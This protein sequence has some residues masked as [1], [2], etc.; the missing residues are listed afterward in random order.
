ML[1]KLAEKVKTLPRSC[2]NYCDTIATLVNSDI[3]L[4]AEQDL[5]SFVHRP[6]HANLT[7]N[8]ILE[9]KQSLIISARIPLA[10]R[11]LRHLRPVHQGFLSQ[12]E[13]QP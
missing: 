10:E 7:N 13:Q 12:P 5:V 8:V 4:V 9:V 6:I 11:N 2:W 3:A 1:R